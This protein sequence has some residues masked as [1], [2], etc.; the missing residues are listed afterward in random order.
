VHAYINIDIESNL[1]LLQLDNIDLNQHFIAHRAIK[2]ISITDS[3]PSR[4]V[5]VINYLGITLFSTNIYLLLLNTPFEGSHGFK[6]LFTIF[7]F[8]FVINVKLFI[9]I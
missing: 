6:L 7:F 5:V 9:K 3:V 4:R 8:F 2:S 1:C